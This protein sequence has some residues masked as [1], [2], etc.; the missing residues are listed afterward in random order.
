MRGELAEPTAL[1]RAVRGMDVVFHLAAD[2]RLAGRAPGRMHTTNVDGT[3]RVLRAAA[4]AG[5]ERI[6]YTSSA[7]T[8]RCP[9][10][11]KTAAAGTEEDFVEPHECRGVYQLTKVVAEQVAWRMIGE[12]APIT[13]VNPSTAIGPGDRRPTPTGRLIVEYLKGHVPAFL[14]AEVNVVHVDDVAR[15][16]WLAATRGESGRRYILA[17]EN[18]SLGRFFEI[19]SEVSGRPAPRLRIPYV[20]A[21]ASGIAGTA[22]SRVVGGEPLASLDGVRMARIPMRYDSG[23]A[24]RELGLRQTP[25]RTAMEEAVAWFEG[26]AFG[27]AG[28]RR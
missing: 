14:D 23:R 24:R 7:V 8:V 16:H 28:R 15:G 19:L 11:G 1:R 17:N 18:L 3:T 25:I 6:I 4:D 26:P 13:I 27:N 10:G 22:W 21:F 5:V 9:H 2:Y 12:G 20:V